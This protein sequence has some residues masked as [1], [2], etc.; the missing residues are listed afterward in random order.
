MVRGRQYSAAVAACYPIVL[1]I[2]DLVFLRLLYSLYNA[3]TDL[4]DLLDATSTRLSDWVSRSC[5]SRSLRWVLLDY[6][7]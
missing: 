1:A 3:P 6:L 7:I 5:S 4:L 2:L